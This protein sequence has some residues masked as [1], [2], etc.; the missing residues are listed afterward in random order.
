MPGVCAYVPQVR[1]LHSHAKLYLTRHYSLRGS[2]MLPFGITSCSTCRISRSGTRRRSKS[3]L[4]SATS[5]FWRTAICP[6]SV[7]EVSTFLADRRHEVRFL[8]LVQRYSKLSL[9]PV[10][11]ARAVY[12]RAAILLLD[13][14]LSAGRCHVTVQST[15]PDGRLSS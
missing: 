5:R 9:V 3:V 10:S 14:V 1:A 13:D 7:S 12:S 2:A 8:A 6:R 11:L 15:A 4:S